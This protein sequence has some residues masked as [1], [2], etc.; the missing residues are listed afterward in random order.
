MEM[1]ILNQLINEH[2]FNSLQILFLEVSKL[3]HGILWFW[4]LKELQNKRNALINFATY[5][6]T[7]KSE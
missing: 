3:F 1:Q 4:I 6:C 5:H 2:N 7:Y